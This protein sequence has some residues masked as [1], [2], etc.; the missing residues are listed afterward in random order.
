M[1]TLDL[2]MV[3]FEIVLMANAHIFFCNEK[4][5]VWYENYIWKKSPYLWLM[6]TSGHFNTLLLGK[7]D[8]L[9]ILSSPELTAQVS[10]PDRLLFVI[11][12]SI[13]PSVC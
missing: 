9:I 6:V 10:F 11:P 3:N 8:P 12:S 4:K 2:P 13:L 7:I 1:I 5:F